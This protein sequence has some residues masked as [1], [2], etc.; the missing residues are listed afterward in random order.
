M[1]IYSGEV[2]ME[3]KKKV[4]VSNPFDAPEVKDVGKVNKGE[5]ENVDNVKEIDVEK[6]STKE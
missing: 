1:G 3:N 2:D 4:E 6:V 5:A